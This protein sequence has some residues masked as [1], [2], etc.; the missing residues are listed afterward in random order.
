MRRRGEITVSRDV[1][2]D[3]KRTPPTAT[4]SSVDI[5]DYNEDSSD[6]YEQQSGHS[7]SD[8]EEDPANT[9][10]DEVSELSDQHDE[11]GNR[12]EHLNSRRE[13]S[14]QQDLLQELDVHKTASPSR[15]NGWKQQH[16]H[17]LSQT[18]R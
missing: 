3:E 8:G 15:L 11:Q 6:N 2:F 5:G 14:A 16:S 10:T 13:Q 9:S 17:L 4:K 12:I 18:S 1:V 7:S